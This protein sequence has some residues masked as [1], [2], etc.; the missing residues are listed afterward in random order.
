MLLNFSM[1]DFMLW[2]LIVPIAIIF[3]L[4]IIATV[5]RIR[6]Q[7]R[8][9]KLKGS[10]GLD[11]QLAP[12]LQAYGGRENIIS[13]S[14]VMSRINTDVKEIELVNGDALKA[15]G[16]TGVLLIGQT[17]KCSFGERAE[18]IYNMLKEVLK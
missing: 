8:Y 6:K 14:Q 16:A 15:L 3:I 5:I 7:V 11:D 4:I 12:F 1:T 13:V 17:V 9:H 2:L 10:G 18:N